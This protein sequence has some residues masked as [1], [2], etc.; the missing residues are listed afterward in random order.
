MASTTSF[1]LTPKRSHTSRICRRSNSAKATSR[2]GPTETSKVSGAP[3]GIDTGPVPRLTARPTS[4][5]AVWPTS[6][7]AR[8]ARN[9]LVTKFGKASVRSLAAEGRRAGSQD[10]GVSVAPVAR[11]EASPERCAELSAELF[12]DPSG[13]RSSN[14]AMSCAPATP[15]TTAW[16]TLAIKPTR[17]SASPSIT[18][19]SHGGWSGWSG[20][21]I[22]SDT[23]RANSSGP[24]GAG[25]AARYRWSERSRSGSS[26]NRGTSRPNGTAI[27][28][29][30][31]AGR[32][33][34]LAARTSRTRWKL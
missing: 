26:T 6:R 24:P 12:S 1:T 28:R 31:S 23:F 11:E 16:W 21:L 19:I 7:P 30:R 18:C 32:A 9:G 10:G 22:T 14:W 4:R 8:H 13:A 5:A 3:R 25:R 15:S 20:R 29:R 17:P 34:T 27:S 33:G 2:R